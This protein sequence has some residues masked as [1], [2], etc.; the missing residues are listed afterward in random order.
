MPKVVAA[1]ISKKSAKEGFDSETIEEIAQDSVRP[2]HR[3]LETLS[4]RKKVKT[5]KGAQNLVTNLSKTENKLKYSEESKDAVSPASTKI[6]TF[7]KTEETTPNM[8]AQTSPAG[9][10]M[11]NMLNMSP[12]KQLYQPL[13]QSLPGSLSLQHLLLQFQLQKSAATNNLLQSYQTLSQ[14]L[15]QRVPQQIIHMSSIL[16]RQPEISMAANFFR[17]DD[18]QMLTLNKL[19]INNLANRIG[20]IENNN[21]LQISQV[22]NRL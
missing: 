16:P 22:S 11:P 1:T 4:Q 17:T 19:R 21:F 7:V 15:S 13:L 14:Q 10:F 5:S 2:S 9:I 8:N 18:L 3:K 6:E 12:Q 20:T